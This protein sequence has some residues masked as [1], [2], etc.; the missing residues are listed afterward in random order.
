MDVYEYA[1]QMEKDGEAYY[2]DAALKTEHKGTRTILTMLADAEVAHYY[3]LKQ[4]QEN[5]DIPLEDSK[6]LAAVKNVFRQIAESKDFTLV[7]PTQVDLYKTALDIEQKSI[8]LYEEQ[9]NQAGEGRNRDVF[10]RVADEERKHYFIIEKLID[11]V[12]QPDRWLENP[13]WYHLE[14]Y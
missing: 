10:L 13:E 1:M 14:D 3:V 12:S 4:L 9:A 8:K 2:R 7:K 11:F 5:Q 6:T